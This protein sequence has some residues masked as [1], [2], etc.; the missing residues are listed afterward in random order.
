LSGEND[1]VVEEVQE[2]AE[3]LHDLYEQIH[4]MAED[5]LKLKRFSE[6][7][8]TERD[9]LADKLLEESHRNDATLFL[10]EMAQEMERVR[11]TERAALH[12]V[13]AENMNLVQHLEQLTKQN[14]D[15]QA[16]LD[17]IK[18]KQQ[19]KGGG[20]SRSISVV[21]EQSRNPSPSFSGVSKGVPVSKSSRSIGSSRSQHYQTRGSTTDE[22]KTERGFAWP[23]PCSS[24]SKGYRKHTMDVI[25][26]AV[27]STVSMTMTTSK[28][29]IKPTRAAA[30][31]V[32]QPQGQPQQPPTQSQ[33]G[34]LTFVDQAIRYFTYYEAESQTEPPQQQH[35]STTT[36]NDTAG[37]V[38][39][40][41]QG[42]GH[43][44]GNGTMLAD[45]TL[46]S[47]FGR[48]S[49]DDDGED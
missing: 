29:K 34:S 36:G 17:F 7:I 23:P 1:E 16:E 19:Q 15:M 49:C 25:S 40:G 48:F 12:A 30:A 4:T 31:A 8:A 6:E 44:N 5:K 38:L 46:L 41:K 32:P 28:S 26:S 27:S 37:G 21:Q 10:E 18:K 35:R 22:K 20:S 39:F 47:P 43:E 13:L 9:E 42:H 11:Q 33:R 45:D 2:M 24:R 3:E 14:D